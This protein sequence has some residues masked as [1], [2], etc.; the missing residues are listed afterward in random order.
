MMTFNGEQIFGQPNRQV[1]SDAR[2]RTQREIIPGITG[3]R[4][5]ILGKESVTIVVEGRLLEFSVSQLIR[6]LQRGQAYVD[7]NF[8]TFVGSGN[9]RYRLC[10]MKAFRQTARIQSGVLTGRKLFTMP[11]VATIEWAAPQ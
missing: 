11:I 5:Y 9:I 4:N 3:Y 2:V 1:S 7:G 6:A 8:Y 10:E